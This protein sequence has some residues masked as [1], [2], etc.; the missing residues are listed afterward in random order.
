MHN[1]NVNPHLSVRGGAHA[2]DHH[3]HSW[4]SVP[5]LLNQPVSLGPNQPV[6]Y[7][8]SPVFFDFS[9]AA[10][11]LSLDPT[12]PNCDHLDYLLDSYS[13]SCC[14]SDLGGACVCH[15][16]HHQSDQ[17][18]SFGTLYSNSIPRW[19]TLA[20]IATTITTATTAKATIILYTKKNEKERVRQVLEGNKKDEE[21]QYA[22]ATT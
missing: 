12:S 18:R 6:D 15:Q 7:L 13:L 19:S 5:L 21:Q 11:L 1:F 8:E 22:Q 2:E 3:P 17:L 9:S 20:T 14:P 10:K 16:Y 4:L